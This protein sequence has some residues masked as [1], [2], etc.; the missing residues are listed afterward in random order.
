MTSPEAEAALLGCII[1]DNAKLDYVNTL[2][3]EFHDYRNQ[4][5]WRVMREMHGGGKYI[6]AISLADY[7]NRSG[8]LERV[9]GYD[10]LEELQDPK[11]MPA[12]SQSY[13]KTV[14]ECHRKRR[15]ASLFTAGAQ[16]KGESDEVAARVMSELAGMM[17]AEADDKPM[18]E[19]A[20]DF[21]DDCMAERAGTFPWWCAEWDYKLGKLSDEIVI[22]QAPRSTGKTALMLQWIKRVHEEKHL[23][24]LASIEMLKEKLAP[25][26]IAN[27]GQVN[28]LNMKRR[29]PTPD[30]QKKARDAV[31][32]IASLNLS[33]RDR[34]MTIDDIKAWCAA[35][36]RNGAG[37]FFIDN[38]LSISEG[39]RKYDSKTAMYDYFFRQ[40]REIRDM[41]KVPLIVLA[42]PNAEGGV[43]WSKDAENFSDIIFT[44]NNWEPE[45][46]CGGKEI[47]ENHECLGRQQV[48]FFR[49]NRDGEYGT[50]ATVDFYGEHQTFEHKEWLV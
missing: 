29:K 28:T 17:T 23:A 3:E 40:F 12:H 2:P 48:A 41:H 6:D 1:F 7:L 45:I 31:R 5:L 4:E 44:L 43:A 27:V 15:L 22:F 18:D 50:T 11:V 24:P 46:K 16:D 35:E 25:R 9:G 42:H 10:R 49:K 13:A 37:A 32:Y 36:M 21:I 19:H 33:V 38:L 26:L 14:R 20:E 30:E 47:Y 34:G 39:E 8:L